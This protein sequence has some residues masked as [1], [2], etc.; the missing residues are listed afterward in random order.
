MQEPESSDLKLP[1][2][3]ATKIE[4]IQMRDRKKVAPI[5]IPVFID[6][7]CKVDPSTS[8]LEIIMTESS[9]V[10]PPPMPTSSV[11]T[12]RDEFAILI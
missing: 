12:V 10:C 6:C 1:E 11:V 7:I 8:M 3:F 5:P 4:E 9:Q 2:Q